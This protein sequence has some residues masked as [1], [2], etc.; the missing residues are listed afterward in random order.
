MPTYLSKTN[1]TYYCSIYYKSYL[2]KTGRKMKRG[3]KTELEANEWEA[4]FLNEYKGNLEMTFNEFYIIYLKDLCIRVSN[5]TYERKKYAMDAQILPYFM[6]KKLNSIRPIDIREWQQV[7]LEKKLAS[8]YVRNLFGS[9]SQIFELAIIMFNLSSNPCKIAKTIGNRRTKKIIVMSPTT[10]KYFFNSVIEI[11]FKLIFAILYMTGIRL[12]ELLALT[13]NDINFENNSL[14]ISKSAI[15]SNGKII[16]KETKTICSNRIITIPKD[17]I[18]LLKSYSVTKNPTNL[19]FT[20]TKY[21]IHSEISRYCKEINY[22]KIRI[23]DFRHSH[24]SYLLQSNV[25]IVEVSNRLGHENVYTTLKTYA[26][27]MPD[28]HDSISEKLDELSSL[29][30]LE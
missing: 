16:I 29:V 1:N 9:L 28:M 18:C 13:S 3:F 25:N 8:S 6:N 19:L 27:L 11:E 26:H 7:V 12:G 24:A 10:F 5:S 4:S 22:V 14:T 17:L 20:K 30:L 23:H 21:S 2:G 15:V